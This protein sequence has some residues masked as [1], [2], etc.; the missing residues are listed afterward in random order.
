MGTLRGMGSQV[1]AGRD[2]DGKGRDT[3]IL[4]YPVS[5]LSNSDILT[6]PLPSP[7]PYLSHFIFTCY[8][9]R[10][11]FKMVFSLFTYRKRLLSK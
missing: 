11:Y 6:L 8:L 10:H 1:A 3:G 2:M 9:H 4:L 5:F 7:L